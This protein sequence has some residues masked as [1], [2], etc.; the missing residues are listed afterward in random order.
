[1]QYNEQELPQQLIVW[2]RNPN[3]THIYDV[4]L[5]DLSAFK[6]SY[7]RLEC[8]VVIYP[9]S[10]QITANQFHIYPYEEYIKD[11]STGR[12][13]AYQRIE[14]QLSKPTAPLASLWVCL[15]WLLLLI[16]SRVIFFRSIRSYLFSGHTC[17]AKNC[18]AT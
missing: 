8:H 10:R 4:I 1:M 3:A 15:L 16:G 13:S 5:N 11:I 7:D 2:R 12:K 6:H 18:G 17:W 14:F 9:Y